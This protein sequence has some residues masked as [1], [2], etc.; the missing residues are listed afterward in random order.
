MSNPR[1]VLLTGLRAISV[2]AFV[3]AAVG[4]TSQ[5]A[6][7]CECVAFTK[8]ELAA[9]STAVFTGLAIDSAEPR[10]LYP[11]SNIPESRV[12]FQVERVY[13]GPVAARVT[14]EAQGGSEASCG[15]DFRRGVRYTVFARD[16]DD[17]G[18]L[19]TNLCFQN[20]QGGIVPSEYELP[21][22]V[23]PGSAAGIAA[24]NATLLIVAAVG[25][26]VLF[27]G[28]IIGRTR[29]TAR[30]EDPDPV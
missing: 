6:A 19:N 12:I 15:S 4:G 29:A 9:E 3:A 24:N 11:Y 13:K 22:G 5:E 25:I 14:I 17:N 20:V 18:T 28:M 27:V 10:F 16:Y 8:R 1:S 21:I 7:A 30:N 26:A 23:D 2:A